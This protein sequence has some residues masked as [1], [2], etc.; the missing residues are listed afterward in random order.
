[1]SHTL[2]YFNYWLIS[3]TVQDPGPPTHLISFIQRL[4]SLP[5]PQFRL[6]PNYASKHKFA[7]GTEDTETGTTTQWLDCQFAGRQLL[8]QMQLYSP[9]IQSYE[10]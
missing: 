2:F 1:M 6:R 8:L 7:A 4:I 9:V 10:T 5:R 3:Q